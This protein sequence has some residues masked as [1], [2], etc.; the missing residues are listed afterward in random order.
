MKKI[1]TNISRDNHYKH[2]K[3]SRLNTLVHACMYMCTYTHMYT[4][5]HTHMHTNVD[6]THNCF[7]TSRLSID[8]HANKAQVLFY[9]FLC[10]LT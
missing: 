9:H 8:F 10:I 7:C 4:C 6:T 3:L 5:M 2:F 1:I